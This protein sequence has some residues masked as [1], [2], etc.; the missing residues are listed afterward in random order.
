MPLADDL[1]P[2]CLDDIVGQKHL[3]G[4]DKLI[5]NLLNNKSDYFPNLIMTGP[6][7]IGKTSLS[8]VIC[9]ELNFNFI[10]LNATT[11]NIADIQAALKETNKLG[12]T[13]GLVLYIDEIHKFNRSTQQ[14]LLDYIEKGKVKL[15]ASTT[16]NPYHSIQKGI[17]SRSIVI[18]L[19]PLEIDDI[20]E[21]LKRG[22]KHLNK[23][24]YLNL[25][26]KEDALSYI[27]TLSNG[28]MRSALNILE[29]VSYSTP[30]NEKGI[31]VVDANRV[32]NLSFSKHI[33]MDKDGDSHYDTISAFQKAIRGSDCDAALHYLARLIKSGDLDIIC[34]RLAI[35]SAEDIGLANPNA[36][37]IV[38]SCIDIAREVGLKESIYPLSHAVVY[39]ATSPKSSST[40]EAIKSALDDLDNKY[41]SEIP[42]HLKDSHYKGAKKLGRG[43]DYLYPHNYPHHYVKQQYM[44]DSLNGTVYY[45]P[46]DNKYENAIK[47]YMD[48]LKTL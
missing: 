9:K 44:P 24:E 37:S 39:L 23:S 25:D 22:V 19:K 38:K 6:P 32:N 33:N 35:I 42:S 36:V 46:Q 15:I 29:L 4:K 20:A 30:P 2:K 17:I 18:E 47:Q 21:G 3:V 8:E 12:N 5:T 45:H 26:I 14:I 40:K 41:I 13:N 1:R 7:G 11:S 43:V 10:K 27:A 48:F 16:E 34:R 28:D 31:S